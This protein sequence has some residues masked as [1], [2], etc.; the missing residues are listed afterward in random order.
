MNECLTT[1]QHEY[2]IGFWVSDN[3]MRL[4]ADHSKSTL[5]CMYL[6]DIAL[7]DSSSNKL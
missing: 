7:V 6:Q 1:P 5:L 4:S 3:D 2:S